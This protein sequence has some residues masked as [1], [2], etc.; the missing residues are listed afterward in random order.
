MAD[1]AEAAGLGEPVAANYFTSQNLSSANSTGSTVSMTGTP[2]PSAS[3]APPS[4][5]PSTVPF[6][7]EAAEMRTMGCAG[8]IG[9]ITMVVAGFAV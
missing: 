2:M 6:L 9:L 3:V 8:L 5:N 7:G 1:F 4:G